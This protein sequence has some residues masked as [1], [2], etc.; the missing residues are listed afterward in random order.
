MILALCFATIISYIVINYVILSGEASPWDVF[1]M[2]AS[3]MYAIT[4]AIRNIKLM[5]YLVVIPHSCAVAYNLLIKAP[6]SSTISYGIELVITI[7]A[8]I[9]FSIQKKG[10]LY[11]CDN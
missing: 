4:F 5:R 6:I 1:Y 8:I 10:Y 11:T 2:V 7:V 3:C 9:K